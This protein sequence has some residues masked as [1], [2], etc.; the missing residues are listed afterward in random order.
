MFFKAMDVFPEKCSS[1]PYCE[2]EPDPD[3]QDWTERENV[4]IYCKLQQKDV[5][6]SIRPPES[7]TYVP[8]PNQCILKYHEETLMR[9]NKGLD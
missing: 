1:C 2:I 9:M 8:D 5:V 3:F 7:V 4:K 6:T